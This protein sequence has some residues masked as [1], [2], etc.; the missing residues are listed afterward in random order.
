MIDSEGKY[1]IQECVICYNDYNIDNAIIFDCSHHICLMCYEKMMNK[2]DELKCPLCR[3]IIAET[4]QFPQTTWGLYGYQYY[5]VIL[6]CIIF[7]IMYV[8]ATLWSQL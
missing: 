3:R 4:S 6:Y 7:V 1:I 8:F 5:K 2:F